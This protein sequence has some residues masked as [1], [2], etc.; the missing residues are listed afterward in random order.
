MRS[1]IDLMAPILETGVVAVVRI[2]RTVQAMRMVE[3]LYEGGIRAVEITMTTPGALDLIGEIAQQFDGKVLVGAGTV[4]DSETAVAAI[5]RGAQFVVSPFLALDVVAACRRHSRLV[6]PGAFTPT[7]I[8]TAWEH[9]ADAVKVFPASALGPGFFKDL[10]GPLPD[11]VVTPTG[12]INLSNAADYIRAGANFIGA[13]GALVDKGIVA[14]ERWSDL[15]DRALMFME[16][17]AAGR[18]RK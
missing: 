12:G 6:F 5:T 3:S 8:M 15:T 18:S 9:G 1:R 14:E 17:V 7:E 4:L 11:V 13:G 2:N 10:R 16:Q